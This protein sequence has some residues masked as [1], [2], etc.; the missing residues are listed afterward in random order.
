AARGADHTVKLTLVDGL[1]AER[2]H[3]RNKLLA[4][5]DT[6]RRDLDAGGSMDAMDRFNEQATNILTSGRFAA[7]MDLSKET[8]KVLDRYTA[9]TDPKAFRFYTSEDGL[10]VRKLLLARRLIEAGVRCVSVSF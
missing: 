3:E 4:G 8:P 1:T 10:S 5:F 7:A 2:L 6:M 9:P